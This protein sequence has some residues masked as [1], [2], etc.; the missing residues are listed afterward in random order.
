MK[1]KNIKFLLILSLLHISFLAMSQELITGVVVDRK[2]GKPLLNADVNIIVEGSRAGVQTDAQGR[3]NILTEQSSGRLRIALKGYHTKKSRFSVSG[4]VTDVGSLLLV[5]KRHLLKE[6]LGIE[7][8]LIDVA[9]LRETP[10]ASSTLSQADIRQAPA[11]RSFPGLFTQMPST[12]FNDGG[13]AS[14]MHSYTFAVLIK[15]T[16]RSC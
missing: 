7:R 5:P 13:G 9:E 3:F 12:Y 2:T 10:I 15:P 11:N 4:E 8:N 1:A 6:R 16:S 14:E